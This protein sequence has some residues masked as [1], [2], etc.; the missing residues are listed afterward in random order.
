MI[1]LDTHILVWYIS[2]PKKLSTKLKKTIETEIKKS[3]ILVSSISI[4]EIYMLVK[5][6]KLTL[7][8]DVD[9]W[10]EQIEQSGVFRFIPVDNQ[11]AAKSVKLNS[12]FHEDPADRIIMAT[13]LHLG[14][15]L[16]IGDEKISKYLS[17][18]P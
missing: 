8:L 10:I 6:G 18:L 14:A 5:K 2:D 13:A 7:S 17:T 4:W 9:S 1:I 16:L 15:K 11:I 12:S 3:E